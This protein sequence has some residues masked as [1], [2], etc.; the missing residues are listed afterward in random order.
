[1]LPSLDPGCLL[2]LVD[3]D[4]GAGNMWIS[5]AKRFLGR[6]N[7]SHGVENLLIAFANEMKGWPILTIYDRQYE[8]ITRGADEWS[9]ALEVHV[10]S[11][12]GDI[13]D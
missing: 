5:G 10:D 8:D 12:S 9:I 7:L 6:Q 11:D 2:A 13:G 1:M 4:I 3:D